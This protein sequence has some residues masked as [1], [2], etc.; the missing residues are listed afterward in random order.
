M[1]IYF[2][3]VLLVILIINKINTTD[4]IEF[5]KKLQS[6]N[7]LVNTDNK[8]NKDL[9]KTKNYNL[10]ILMFVPNHKCQNLIFDVYEND[11]KTLIVS[12]V[13][14]EYSKFASRGYYK[15]YNKNNFNLKNTNAVMLLTNKVIYKTKLI[16]LDFIFKI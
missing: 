8:L 11:N 6:L 1:K 16:Y 2:S 10:L 3:I 4:D 14:I 12:D 9:D 5:I 7:I 15:K 13:I